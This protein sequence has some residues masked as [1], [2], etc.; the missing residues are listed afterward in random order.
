MCQGVVFSK[1][2]DEQHG[3]VVNN[4]LWIQ[5]DYFSGT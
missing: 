1:Q 4:I 5:K 3:P 2:H